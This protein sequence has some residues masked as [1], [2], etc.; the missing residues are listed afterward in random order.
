MANQNLLEVA[1]LN[2]SDEVVGLIEEV[3]TEVPEIELFPART[4]RGTSYKTVTRTSLPGTGFRAANEGVTPG[5]SDFKTEVIEMYIVDG[6]LEMDVRVADADER[7]AAHMLGLEAVG[8]AKSLLINL[9]KQIY[10]GTATDAKGFPGLKEFTPFGSEYVLDATGSAADTASSV[11]FVKMGEQ[12]AN[13]LWGD[14]TTLTLGDWRKEQLTDSNDS[15]KK[16]TGYVNDLGGWCGLQL[17][18]KWSAGRILNLTAEATKGLTVD[19][20][21]EA[22]EK[23]PAAKQPDVAFLSR[24]SMIQLRKDMSPKISIKS[25]SAATLPVTQSQVRDYIEEATGV[26]LVVSDS[27][28]DTDAIES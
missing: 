14:N 1:K 3:I 17:A 12:D 18:S 19:R 10:Y 16:Y 2:G 25:Q 7:G 24:R 13:M 8:I 26:R 9:A 23:F 15:T 4:I 28:S 6:Q 21:L 22:T 27:I 11:F 5:K 20:F